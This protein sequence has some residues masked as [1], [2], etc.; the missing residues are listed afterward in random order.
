MKSVNKCIYLCI[1]VRFSRHRG[2]F[3]PS[4]AAYSFLC[5]V[6]LPNAASCPHKYSENLDSSASVAEQRQKRV[7]ELESVSPFLPSASCLGERSRSLTSKASDSGDSLAYL[8]T[9]KPM[10]DNAALFLVWLHPTGAKPSRFT[11]KWGSNF[12][13]PRHD[14]YS[15]EACR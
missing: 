9:N 14:F 7:I 11:V 5:Y 15:D 1:S 3:R 4:L 10:S 8:K 12:D 2:L 6:Q 13:E